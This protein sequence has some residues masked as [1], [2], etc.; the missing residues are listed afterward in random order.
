MPR[1]GPAREADLRVLR[2]DGH[3][4]TALGRLTGDALPPLLPTVTGAAVTLVLLLA[5][6]GEVSGITLFAPA[7]VLLLSGVAAGHPHDGRFDWMAPPVLRA[8]E[9]LYLLALGHQAGVPGPLVY[10]LLTTVAL[11]HGDVVH[12]TRWAAGPPAWVMRAMLGWDGRMLLVAAGG[13]LGWL[14]FT[15]GL[16][17]GYLTV[18]LVWE[19]TTSWLATPVTTAGEPPRNGWGGVASTPQ[20]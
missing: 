8:T 11:H 10:V 18:L 16:L 1:P 6:L 7:A 5:G 20:T 15:Y 12:R 3:L 13:M 19:T 4:A 9:Y 17:A 14:P 2:D